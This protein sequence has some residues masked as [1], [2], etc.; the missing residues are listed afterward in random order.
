[1]EGDKTQRP[2][3]LIPANYKYSSHNLA[4]PSVEVKLWA[5]SSQ[6]IS[7]IIKESLNDL[8]DCEAFLACSTARCSLSPLSNINNALGEICLQ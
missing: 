8:A 7:K 4:W 2:H 6:T 1:M 3:K 5:V